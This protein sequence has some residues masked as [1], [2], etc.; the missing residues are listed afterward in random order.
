MARRRCCSPRERT[1][2][3]AA[4]GSFIKK[5]LFAV[6]SSTIT[7]N[8]EKGWKNQKNFQP[9]RGGTEFPHNLQKLRN[10]TFADQIQTKKE[11]RYESNRHRPAGR[12]PRP[13]GYSEGNSP[14]TANQ[15]GQP[16]L[17]SLTAS[18]DYLVA[19]EELGRRLV[20]S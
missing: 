17:T 19:M 4:L 5:L 14:H 11:N 8:S 7:H 10:T 6:M 18:D 13:G 12:Q 16:L 9:R 2:R 15:G 1:G 20:R 3:A